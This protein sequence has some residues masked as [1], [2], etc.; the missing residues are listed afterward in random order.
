MD[1]MNFEEWLKINQDALRDLIKQGAPEKS[2]N[3]VKQRCDW[4]ANMANQKEGPLVKE[5]KKVQCCFNKKG[6][7]WFRG[8]E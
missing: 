8:D 5:K 6:G 1:K 3:R 2:I 7:G 4:L